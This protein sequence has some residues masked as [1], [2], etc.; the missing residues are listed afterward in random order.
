MKDAKADT[1]LA[2]KFGVTPRTVRTWRKAGAPLDDEARLHEWIA[3][4]SRQKPDAE[5]ASLAEARRQKICLDI[6]RGE[7]ELLTRRGELISLAEVADD[8]RRIG[9]IVCHAVR[10]IQAVAPLWEGLPAASIE[11]AAKRI[12]D[13]V[14]STIHEHA[15]AAAKRNTVAKRKCQGA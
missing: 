8:F 6:R 4:Q 15:M 2:A 12:A 1:A 3:G 5:P 14:V 10:R 9:Q 13:E 11:T 7:L